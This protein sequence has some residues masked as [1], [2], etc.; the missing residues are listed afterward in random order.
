MCLKDKK[1]D[2]KMQEILIKST[3]DGAMQPAYHWIAPGTAPRPLVVALHTWSCDHTNSSGLYSGICETLGF[4]LIY[5]D[6]RGPNWTPQAC[7]STLAMSDLADARNYAIGQSNIDMERIYLIGGSGEGHASLLAA[8]RLPELWSAV[9]SWCPISDIAAWHRECINTRHKGY[10]EH[11]EKACEG[12]PQE[13]T[14]ARL[15]AINRSPL[16]WLPNAANLIV[17]IN[18][19]I[20]DG[21]TGS[22]P[23]SHAINA[24][25]SLAA[26][27]DRI[28]RD[29]I[30]FMLNN[31]RV[32]EHLRWDS[33]DPAYAANKVL[34]RKISG[35]AR[36]TLFEGGH[37]LLGPAGLAFLAECRRGKSP[38]WSPRKP[39]ASSTQTQLGK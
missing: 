30:S 38:D 35:N 33:E 3:A 31:E 28:S 24:F 32:P 21:H 25:N 26:K 19:G 7:G 13:N 34:L 39:V 5:P 6:F 8:G 15:E 29:D 12:N 27:K 9:S 14:H 36:L 22:V 10:S 2:K 16:T 20:H 23:V 17:D 1:Q 11:I 37:D 18:T 4:D